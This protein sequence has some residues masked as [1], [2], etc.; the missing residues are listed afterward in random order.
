MKDSDVR[1]KYYYSD[2]ETRKLV[3]TDDEVNEDSD[4]NDNDNVIH[5]RGVRHL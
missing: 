4:Y 2:N 5:K 3:Y 1:F